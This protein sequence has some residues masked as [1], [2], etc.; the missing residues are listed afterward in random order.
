M[1][2]RHNREQ[3]AALLGGQI[4]R[5]LQGVETFRLA[6]GDE[7]T[8]P[9]PPIDGT[10]DEVLPGDEGK[11]V[12]LRRYVELNRAG[13]QA[14][15]ALW[16]LA[17]LAEE[18][19][20]IA[21]DG[22]FTQAG[23]DDAVRET[24][25]ASIANLTDAN[26][27]LTELEIALI[28]HERDLYAVPQLE[29]TD[30][31]GALNDREV[32]EW[33]RSLHGREREAM[34][35][36]L[37]SGEADVVNLALLR[38]PVPFGKLE[39][40]SLQGWRTSVERRNPDAVR[41]LAADHEQLRWAMLLTKRAAQKIAEKANL[42]GYALFEAAAAFSLVMPHGPRVFFGDDAEY[43]AHLTRW[44]AQRKRAA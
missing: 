24:R 41:Q 14:N 17:R 29:R 5:S 21:Q 23:R 28:N 32:R 18:S 30:Y 1:S 33:V 4:R 43:R 15:R 6:D 25:I 12:R 2:N 36:R 31:V 22:R 42:R 39:T 8:Y 34:L 40:I 10:S 9:P 7:F 44:E 11:D 35:P 13:E 20:R 37:A 26:R 38:S 27:V 3:A 16:S 19:H